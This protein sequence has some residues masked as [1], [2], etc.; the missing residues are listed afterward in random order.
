MWLE[1]EDGKTEVVSGAALAEAIQK[2]TPER[3]PCLV[4]LASCQSAARP[5]AET[6]REGRI[7]PIAITTLGAR[8]VE[9]GVPA[10]LAMQGNISL[11][12]LDGFMPVFFQE[13]STHG[14]VD[15]A[16]AVAR[17]QVS[18][19]PDAWMPLLWMRLRDGRLW[20]RYT[21]GFTDERPGF[22]RW[23]SFMK[24]LEQQICTPILGPGMS[25]FLLGTSRQIACRWA[26]ES[27]YPL[28]D[29]SMESL[30]SGSAVP[31]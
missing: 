27:A 13:L 6:V 26:E 28:A 30:P 9:A 16:V 22:G 25:E 20:L 29:D 1:G 10:V 31:G 21:P 8:L 18:A 4:V 2:L 7:K 11:D 19:R 5:S 14:L 17:S 23:K 24:S 12:T 3:R 15:R